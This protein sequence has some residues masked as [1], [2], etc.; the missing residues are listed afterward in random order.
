MSAFGNLFHGQL[1][2][3]RTTQ[4]HAVKWGIEARLN[5][6]TTYSCISPM[7]S[8][9]LA[10]ERS[11]AGIYSFASGEHNVQVGDPLPDTLSSLL[12][13]YPFGYTIVVA[14]P[15]LSNGSTH[16]SG[17]GQQERREC[18]CAGHMENQPAVGARLRAAV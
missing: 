5:R 12:I 6:D 9:T 17:G 8:T 4:R 1:N 11:F 3:V 13:G 15:D 14:P 16:W 18:L 2:F 10:V 7:G